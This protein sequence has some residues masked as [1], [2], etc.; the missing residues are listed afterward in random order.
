M[1]SARRAR[2]LV[3]C[4]SAIHCEPTAELLCCLAHARA[5]PA[6]PMVGARQGGAPAIQVRA[7]GSVLRRK[8]GDPMP[9]FEEVGGAEDAALAHPLSEARARALAA[10]RF[11]S[12]AI[13][14]RR[15]SA[16]GDV[17]VVDRPAPR[18][19][20]DELWDRLGDFA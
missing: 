19:D 4:C 15:A 6:A 10:T 2:E 13:P 14:D 12:A 17:L 11:R 8:I 1:S 7:R 20:P 18:V 3:L 9:R 16:A 5:S